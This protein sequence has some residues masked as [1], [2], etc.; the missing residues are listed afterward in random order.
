[1]R[2]RSKATFLI[3]LCAAALAIGMVWPQKPHAQSLGPCANW[4]C[5]GTYG[6][7]SYSLTCQLGTVN[8]TVNNTLS[9]P[10]CQ[11][12]SNPCNP[13]G[14]GCFGCSGKDA[15]NNDCFVYF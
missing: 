1:M 7:G 3:A 4:T 15:M 11:V 5:T 6:F 2:R 13:S 14:G 8:C 9:I 10:F 12:Q